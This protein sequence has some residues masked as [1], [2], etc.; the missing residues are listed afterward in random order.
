MST[1]LITDGSLDIPPA[2]IERYDISVIQPIVIIDNEE[3]LNG[4][5]ITPEEFFERQRS[6]KVLPQTSQPAPRQFSQAFSEALQT[7]D[8]ILYIGISAALSGTFNSAQ[9]AAQEL[10]ADKIVLHDTRAISAAGGFQV[11]A[12]ARALEQGKSLEEALAAAKRTQQQTELF[13]SVDDLTYLIKGGRIGRL[14]GAI[15]TFLN[16]RPII[17]L[18]KEEGTLV[19]AARVRSFKSAMRKLMDKAVEAVGEGGKGRFMLLYSEE[20]EQEAKTFRDDI[21][22]RFDVCWFDSIVPSPVLC[23]HT[24][25]RAL[26]LVVAKGDW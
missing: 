8:R 5:D 24:G 13:F 16:I 6:A 26:G 19:P 22:A 18:N 21:H 25:P 3:L 17:Q 23:A 20:M 14:A 15:G 2:L 4:I 12:A 9:Q 11:I 7:D 1:K 10:A